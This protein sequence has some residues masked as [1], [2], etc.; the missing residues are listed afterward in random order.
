MKKFLL[1]GTAVL[2][3]VSL[4]AQPRLNKDNNDAVLKAMT[5]EEKATLVV[6]GG[7]GSMTA[8]SLTAFPPF[9]FEVGNQDTTVDNNGTRQLSDYMKEKGLKVEFIARD[10]IHYWSFWQECLPK[11]LVKVGESFK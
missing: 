10:G 3:M 9:T 1:M 5:L 2:C 11:A 6:G 4:F 7:W 8:G